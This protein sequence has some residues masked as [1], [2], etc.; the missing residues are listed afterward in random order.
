MTILT[1]T[2][3]SGR[4]QTIWV[5][6]GWR[7][8]APGCLTEVGFPE[9]KNDMSTN[10]PPQ[11]RSVPSTKYH[12]A[13]KSPGN[14][15]SGMIT[16]LVV[17]TKHSSAVSP[18]ALLLLSWPQAWIEYTTV[19]TQNCRFLGRWWWAHVL[20]IVRCSSNSSLH[21]DAARE[22]PDELSRSVK[23]GTAC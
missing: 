17:V 22:R 15:T 12:R 10:V 7:G 8:T 11:V 18:T 21:W 1:A 16:D 23:N 14:E 4:R 3:K 20:Y 9:R 6:W 2:P 13:P 19:G 5:F